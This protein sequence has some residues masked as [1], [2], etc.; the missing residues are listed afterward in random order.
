MDG[1]K[2]GQTSQMM[3]IFNSIVQPAANAM[4]I[5]YADGL[6]RC[7]IGTETISDDNLRPTE[8]FYSFPH[9]VQC[10]LATPGLDDASLKD[11]P[12]SSTARH[13]QWISP[14]ILT[15][16]SS[17]CHCQQLPTR[18]ALCFQICEATNGPKR[19]HHT[20]WFRG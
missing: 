2:V 15:N 19:F 6:Q 17:R 16:I 11:S 13:R 1:C 20:G 9:E 3:R 5:V 10:G 12:S 14:S 7:S 4:P 18:S 8:A